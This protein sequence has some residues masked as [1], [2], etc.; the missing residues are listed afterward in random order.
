MAARKHR[1]S[2][3]PVLATNRSARFEYELTTLPAPATLVVLAL[4][5]AF[6]VA[7]VAF[8]PSFTDAI[9]TSPGR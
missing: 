5:L 1:K 2:D 4:S 8:T 6:T 3:S 9:S 7:F